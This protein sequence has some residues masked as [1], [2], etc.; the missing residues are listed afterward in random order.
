MKKE[1]TIK[2]TLEFDSKDAAD[3]YVAYFLDGGG[4][5]GGNLDLNWDYKKSKR[6]KDGYFELLRINGTG[7]ALDENGDPCED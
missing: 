2:V 6:A 4:D 7:L 1:K 3:N 5:G